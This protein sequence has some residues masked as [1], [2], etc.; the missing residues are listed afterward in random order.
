MIIFL[1]VIFKLFFRVTGVAHLLRMFSRFYPHFLNVRI[2][3]N[4]ISHI[5]TINQE[6][7]FD[8][9]SEQM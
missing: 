7:L 6:I 4:D 2:R 5:L 3:S 9:C 1:R 8:Q